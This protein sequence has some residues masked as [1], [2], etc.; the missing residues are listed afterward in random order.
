MTIICSDKATSTLPLQ[1]T[2]FICRLFLACSATS[3]YFHMPPCYEGHSMVMNVSLDTAN[4]N[5]INI[6][7][8]GFRI[9]Q[10]L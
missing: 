4:I 3:I 7:T 6:S 10:H 8:P 2:F 5:A 9:W 1:Q